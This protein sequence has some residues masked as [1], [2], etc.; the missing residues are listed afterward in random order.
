[1]QQ[2]ILRYHCLRLDPI[3]AAVEAAQLYGSLRKK[4]LTIRK[5]NDCLI[6][7]HAIRYQMALCHDDSD[8]ELIAAQSELQVVRFPA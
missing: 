1:V 7:V 3:E 4:G 5:P 6:A 8:F 2:S